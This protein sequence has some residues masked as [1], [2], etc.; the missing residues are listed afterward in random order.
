MIR[1]NYFSLLLI[2]S[3]ATK[4]NTPEPE[5]EDDLDIT[6]DADIT[7]TAAT[8]GINEIESDQRITDLEIKV[9]ELQEELELAKAQ[10][11]RV[12]PITELF[13]NSLVRGPKN[14]YYPI[15]GRMTKF[16][17]HLLW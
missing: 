14:G 1:N 17:L 7:L 15:N 4:S 3:A 11:E 6:A 2:I 16:C 12:R 10:I 9:A 8:D 13:K 5:I